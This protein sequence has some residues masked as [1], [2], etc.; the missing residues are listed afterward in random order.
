MGRTT[1]SVPVV[2]FTAGGVRYA[3]ELAATERAL[4]M[5]ALS[6]L[7]G[8][9]PPVVGALNLHGSV[10]PVVDL[11]REPG[12]SPRP[13][14]PDVHLL[15]VR[16][17]RRRLAIAAD[18]VQGVLRL[19]PSQVSSTAA[20]VDGMPG[21]Q[22]IAALPDGGLLFIRDLEALLSAEQERRL[23]LVLER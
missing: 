21:V 10:V 11:A 13:Y 12:R 4:R 19:D 2:A 1:V 20:V 14:A 5:P 7:P 16:T 15:V 6:A 3:V 9:P 22:G 18:E 23:D 17:P 8:A